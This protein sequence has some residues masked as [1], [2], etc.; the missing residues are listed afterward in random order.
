VASLISLQCSKSPGRLDW[1]AGAFLRQA[2]NFDLHQSLAGLHRQYSFLFVR[3]PWRTHRN[4]DQVT[5][6]SEVD[7][8]K[9]RGS[10]AETHCS[11][12]PGYGG[13]WRSRIRC[14][15]FFHSRIILSIWPLSGRFGRG[16][17]FGQTKIPRA[18]ILRVMPCGAIHSVV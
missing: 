8:P 15:D 7:L 10:H 2:A 17:R 5:E 16:N 4:F 6:G 9:N 3:C 11:T 12:H 18:S 14:D 1:S 13:V